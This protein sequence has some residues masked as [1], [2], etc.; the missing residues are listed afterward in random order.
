MRQ[1]SSSSRHTRRD[2]FGITERRPRFAS[3]LFCRRKALPP[4]ARHPRWERR[5]AYVLALL[6]FENAT[7]ASQYQWLLDIFWSVALSNTNKPEYVRTYLVMTDVHYHSSTALLLLYYEMHVLLVFVHVCTI[8]VMYS[9]SADVSSSCMDGVQCLARYRRATTT[10]VQ[11]FET[12][13][14]LRHTT[15]TSKLSHLADCCQLTQI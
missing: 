4:R 14:I 5:L 6:H 2:S 8:I 9:S 1:R 12:H 3:H 15:I 7:E 10:G 11:H 13:N